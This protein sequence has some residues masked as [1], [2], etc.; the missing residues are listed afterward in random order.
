[1]ELTIVQNCPSCGA[2]IEVNEDDRL[3]RCAYCDVNNYRIDHVGARYLLP[4]KLPTTVDEQNLIFI[5]YLR[6]KGSI[7]FV[8]NQEIKHKIVDTTRLGVK[9]NSFPVSLGVRPQAM[10]VASVLS[11]QD[12]RFLQQNVPTKSLFVQ[13][14]RIMDLFRKKENKITHHR[15]FIGETLSRIYLP[16]YQ[17]NDT[18]FD[19]VDG[20][21]LGSASLLEKYR[22]KS[23]SAKISWEPQYV[24]TLCPECGGLLSGRRDSLVLQCSNCRSLWQEIKRRFFPVK[25]MIVPSTNRYSVYLPFW[26]VHFSTTGVE[27]KTLGDFLRYTNQPVIINSGLDQK[28][29]CFII[30]AFKVNSKA[31][32]QI[33]TQLTLSQLKLP[34]GDTLRVYHAYPVTLNQKEAMESVKSILASCSVDRRKVFLDLPRL[35]VEKENSLL[36]YLPFEKHPHD[37]IQEHTG[38]TI[39]TAAM[40]YGRSL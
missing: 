31:F 32:L 34:P 11:S 22:G 39:Q 19:A 36:V 9:D 27:L 7:F 40:K 14:A 17:K 23:C 20:R 6:F 37:F 12:G 26:R 18:L 13:A 38:A 29:L 1:M 4:W 10:K 15:A 28:S 33:A 3:L 5:P 25:W 8:Q 35:R 2:G 24:S 16:I 21:R 30:P